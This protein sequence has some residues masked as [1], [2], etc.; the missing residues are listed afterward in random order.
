MNELRGILVMAVGIALGILVG[1]LL[2]DV[3]NIRV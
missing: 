3:F 2:L 1:F